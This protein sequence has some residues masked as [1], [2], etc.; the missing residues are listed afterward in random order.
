MAAVPPCFQQISFPD[1]EGET[2]LF[3]QRRTNFLRAR[4]SLSLA[5]F[6]FF[7]LSEFWKKRATAPAIGYSPFDL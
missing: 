1:S 5:A 7:A 2:T 6:S 3:C 4:G